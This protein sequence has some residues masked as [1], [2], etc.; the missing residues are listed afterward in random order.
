MAKPVFHQWLF[1]LTMALVLMCLP[2][3]QAEAQTNNPGGPP[4]NTT[5]DRDRD[6]T[7]RLPADIAHFDNGRPAYIVSGP[8]AEAEAAAAA[9]EEGGARLVS[10]RDL[11]PLDRRVMT[12][13]LRRLSLDRARQRLAQAAP[14]FVADFNHLYVTAQE[15][16]R[17]YAAAMVGDPRGGCRV[18]TGQRLGLI[19]GPVALD[20]PA[21]Q[22]ADIVVRSALAPR[23]DAGDT[24]HGTALAALMVG[25]DPG[26]ALNGFAIGARLYAINAFAREHSGVAADVDRIGASL[27]WML[28]NDVRLI[29][30]SFA[31]PQNLVLADLLDQ[32][33]GQGAVMIAAVGNA[34]R[35]AALLPA[36]AETVVAVTAVDAAMRRYRAATRGSHIEFAAPGV[37]VYVAQGAGGGYASGTSYAAPIITALAARIA[38]SS[39]DDLR[40]RLERR[41]FDLGEPGR[42]AQFGWGLVRDIGC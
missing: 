36:S 24:A 30:M 28:L 12:F 34:G 37:D 8:I 15:T 41:A 23:Q 32:T 19:D 29:N 7:P 35:E 21:L 16:P 27:T 40:R 4:A 1:G 10:Y 9:L 18:R 2:P 17:V 20:H 3:Q 25:E 31:G 42:D 13:N 33:A 6:R 5:R 39:V 22:R 26:G 38:P 14:G 11:V